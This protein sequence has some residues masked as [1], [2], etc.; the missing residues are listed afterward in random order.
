VASGGAAGDDAAPDHAQR[1]IGPLV[2][3]HCAHEIP[4]LG[5][6][7]RRRHRLLGAAAA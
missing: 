3:V 2:Q 6:V 5:R 4:T 7:D 1:E